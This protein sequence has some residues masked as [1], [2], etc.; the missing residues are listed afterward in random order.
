LP[1]DR[2]RAL[3][4]FRPLEYQARIPHEPFG[5]SSEGKTP[6]RLGLE[7]QTQ[8]IWNRAAFS[9][10]QLYGASEAAIRANKVVVGM[11]CRFLRA[12]TIKIISERAQRGE[13]LRRTQ[14]N[15]DFDRYPASVDP[16]GMTARVRASSCKRRRLVA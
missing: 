1:P 10:N 6:S 12:M 2:E 9:T 5:S 13:W 14:L 4:G 8:T 11:S 7:C 16:F 3:L 15:E